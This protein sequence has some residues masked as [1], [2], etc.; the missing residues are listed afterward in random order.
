MDK[1]TGNLRQR[2]LSEGL[3]L[4]TSGSVVLAYR[5]SRGLEYLRRATDIH[6]HGMTFD[7]RGFQCVVLLDWRELWPT[8]D[9]PWDRLCDKL[10]GAGVPS[11]HDEMEMLRLKPV[12]DALREAVSPASVR[13]LAEVADEF[14]RIEHLQDS[15]TEMP[16]SRA[17]AR[18]AAVEGPPHLES[19]PPR[20]ET[21][22]A[23]STSQLDQL[24]AIS[25]K[26]QHLFAEIAARIPSPPSE[27]DQSKSAQAALAPQGNPSAGFLDSLRKS[28]AAA[29]R[30]PALAASFSTDWPAASRPILPGV[31]AATRTERTWAPILAFAVLRAFILHSLPARPEFD[32]VALFDRLLLRRALADIFASFGMEGEARWQAAAQVRL[33]LTAAATAPNAAQ[34][35]ALFADPDARWLAGVNES[36]GATY[37]NKEQFEELVT[38]MQ[39]PALLEI[40]QL[41]DAAVRATRITHLEGAVAAAYTAARD[42]GY[43]LTDYLAATTQPERVRR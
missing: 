40:A 20:N 15:A 2:S 13:A 41:Q 42:S 24:R 43:R 38:W 22:D 23:I 6:W 29:A 4:P 21:W 26:S 3:A 37:F 31:D 19:A 1:G 35:H 28:L 34:T 39:L 16:S 25:E 7:L 11:V 8:S 10:N 33:L 12:H 9:W 14:A 27:D 36:S 32:L 30:L 18:S 17:K 5:D